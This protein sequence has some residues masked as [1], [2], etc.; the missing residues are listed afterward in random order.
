[1]AVRLPACSFAKKNHVFPPTPATFAP[2]TVHQVALV[3]C[4][5]RGGGVLLMTEP[6]LVSTSAS[7]RLVPL[8]IHRRRSGGQRSEV[9]GAQV[10]Q[11]LL[12][13]GSSQFPEQEGEQEVNVKLKAL[14]IRRYF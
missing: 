11:H 8:L 2:L 7:A 13:S 3:G 12:S 4:K 6:S 1:M 14:S 9:R 5:G 10:L